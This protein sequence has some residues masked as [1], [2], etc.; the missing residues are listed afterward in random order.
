MCVSESFLCF[1]RNWRSKI[2]GFVQ[3]LTRSKVVCEP[4]KRF[5]N[6]YKSFIMV[7]GDIYRFLMVIL[8]ILLDLKIWWY[9]SR[10]FSVRLRFCLESDLLCDLYN[11]VKVKLINFSF[12][13]LLCNFGLNGVWCYLLCGY[14]WWIFRNNFHLIGR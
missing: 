14:F 1:C 3:G 2:E 8:C 5:T 7:F 13:N 4:S 6:H 12:C 11:F 9:H 10:V